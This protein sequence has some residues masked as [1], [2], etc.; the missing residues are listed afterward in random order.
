MKSFLNIS[1]WRVLI[2]TLLFSA[3][4]AFA[5]GLQLQA[6][7]SPSTSGAEKPLTLE[8]I[9]GPVS[10]ADPVNWWLYLAIG[11]G[12][13]ATVAA[14][15]WFIKKRKKTPMLPSA[16]A[17]ALQKIKDISILQE[18]AP[19]LYVSKISLITR[20]YIERR[21]AI[22]SSKTTGQF[23]QSL[24]TNSQM[25][26][27]YDQE[28]FKE[29]FSLFDTAKFAHRTPSVEEVKN[30]EQAIQNFIHKGGD[31]ALS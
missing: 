26:Q 20:E 5:E 21:F 3:T 8:D 28:F 19:L 22:P 29:F 14:L 1:Q 27:G 4:S 10:I 2:L 25:P 11:L 31:N 16:T 24:T 12:I 7:S 30:I 15:W 23:F 17:I 9:Q 13:V 6:P 18:D